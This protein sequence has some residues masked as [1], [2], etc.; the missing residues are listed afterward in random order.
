[1]ATTAPTMKSSGTKRAPMSAH[2]KSSLAAGVF[3]VIS[4]VSIPTLVLYSAAKKS[5]YIVGPG[6]DTPVLV[7]GLLELIVALAGI[8]SRGRAV[9]GDQEAERRRSPSV[10]SRPGPWRPPPSSPA[11]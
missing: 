5:G 1:M 6:P 2:R 11:W 7:G 4:F 3:Y 9:P 8:G 10:S